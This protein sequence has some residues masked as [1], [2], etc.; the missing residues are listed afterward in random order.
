MPPRR[1]ALNIPQTSSPATVAP[2]ANTPQTLS[3]ATVAPVNTPQILSPATAA[4]VNTPQTLPSDA[5]APVNTPQT[6]PPAAAIPPVAASLTAAPRIARGGAAPRAG[7]SRA[8]DD[9]EFI[10]LDVINDVNE[11][12]NDHLLTPVEV[13]CTGPS[14]LQ[15]LTGSDTTR[16]NPLAMGRRTKQ[17]GSEVHHCFTKDATSGQRVCTPCVDVQK[18]DPSYDVA[19]YSSSMTTGTLQ[20]HLLKFHLRIYIAALEQ[21]GLK[22]GAKEVRDILDI[23]WTLA[24]IGQELDQNPDKLLESFGSPGG[25]SLGSQPRSGVSAPGNDIPD[26]TIEEMHRQLVKFIVV[27]DQVTPTAAERSTGVRHPSLDKTT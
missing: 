8:A 21:Y 22:V 11:E 13:A 20:G 7:P 16:S 9:G 24:H 6:L 10:N 14:P 3:P 12:D 19:E 27:D 26:F 25:G 5:A 2:S 1:R 15:T 23:G 18:E 17:S 4:P